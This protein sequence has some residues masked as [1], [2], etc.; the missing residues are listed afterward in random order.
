MD[1]NKEQIGRFNFTRNSGKY[2]WS[3]SYIYSIDSM[4]YI[5]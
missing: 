1:I 4:R 2:L 3:L 5:I